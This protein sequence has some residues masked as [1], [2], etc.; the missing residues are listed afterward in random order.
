MECVAEIYDRWWE[1]DAEDVDQIRDLIGGRGPLRI[2]EPFCGTGRVL[3]PLAHDGH[4]LTGLDQA[5]AMLDRARAKIERLPREVRRRIALA[6]ADVTSEEWPTGFD[7]LILG[8]NCLYELSTPEEQEHCLA[9]A[10]RALKPGG[11]VY[12]DNDHMEGDLDESWRKP[13]RETGDSYT[14]ADGTRVEFSG[15]TIWY[16][17]PRRL[18]RSRRLMAVIR[19]DGSSAEHEFIVQKHPVSASEVETWLCRHGFTIE[20]QWVTT[21]RATYW[22]RLSAQTSEQHTAPG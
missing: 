2:L 17:A 15:E 20:R 21:G 6:Q 10:A 14:C 13:G 5:Q 3:I 18:H 12:L 7:L 11:Y 16:D 9:S 1:T 4:E 8:G 22:A 19:P